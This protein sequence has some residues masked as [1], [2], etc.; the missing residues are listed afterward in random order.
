MAWLSEFLTG[1]LGTAVVDRTE[2][3]G[4]YAWELAWDPSDPDGP[5]LL[6]G[7]AGEQLGLR[8]ESAKGPVEVLAI[9]HVEKPDAN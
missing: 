9:D 5:S 2:L 8:L 6:H 1:E 3:S 4:T 7:P